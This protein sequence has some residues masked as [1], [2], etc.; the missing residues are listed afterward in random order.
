MSQH[1]SLEAKKANGVLV[2]QQ[3]AMTQQCAPVAK[4]ANSA[5]VDQ[6]LAN[7]WPTDGQEP[8]DCPGG[9]WRP[10]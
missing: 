7:G 10:G 4:K 1:C 5:M 6:Q 2:D 9:Q 8:T 3:L